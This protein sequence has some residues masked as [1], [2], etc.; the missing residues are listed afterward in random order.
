MD[1]AICIQGMEKVQERRYDSDR[2]PTSRVKNNYDDARGLN[3]C[4]DAKRFNTCYDATGL[5][6]YDD[7]TRLKM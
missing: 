5:S 7:V 2:D 3:H 6:A 1:L 4:N